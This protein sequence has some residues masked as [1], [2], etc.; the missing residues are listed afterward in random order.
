MKY[1]RLVPQER[2][3]CAIS[4]ST[5]SEA[6]KSLGRGLL[7]LSL[8]LPLSPGPI[9]TAQLQSIMFLKE[10][11]GTN[12]CPMSYSPSSFVFKEN[13]ENFHRSSLA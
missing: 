6:G 5:N 2:R 9:L 7:P 13:D 1:L 4:G 12:S 10:M 3:G 8:P 11:K